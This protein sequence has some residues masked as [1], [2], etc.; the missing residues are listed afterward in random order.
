MQVQE[1]SYGEA[2]ETYFRLLESEGHPASMISQPGEGA[3]YREDNGWRLRNVNGDLAYVLDSG[4]LGDLA[5]L[6]EDEA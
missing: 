2:V 3:S 1:L 6:S 4:E 5:D